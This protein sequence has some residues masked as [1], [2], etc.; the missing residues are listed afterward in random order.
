MD[1]AEGSQLPDD[2]AWM[3]DAAG[4]GDEEGLQLAQP[5]EPVAPEMA[6][7]DA[8]PATE[9]PEGA[10]VAKPEHAAQMRPHIEQL[11]G[12]LQGW[13]EFAKPY[14]GLEGVRQ[15]SPV[16][17][18]LYEADDSARVEK[19]LT[20]MQG[21]LPD[22]DMQGLRQRVVNDPTF[23]GTFA[24]QNEE[25]LL[26]YFIQAK[27]DTLR[28]KLGVAGAPT[29]LDGDDEFEDD[30]DEPL[31]QPGAVAPAANPE[32]EALRTQIAQLQEQLSGR[33]QQEAQSSAQQVASQIGEAVFGQTVNDS[34]EP[35]QM[36]GWDEQ[37][38]TRAYQIAQ[39]EFERDPQAVAAFKLANQFHGKPAFDGH[40]ARARDIFASKL[41]DAVKMVDAVRAQTRTEAA[42]KPLERQE[43]SSD[44]PSMDTADPN[45]K[46]F[47]DDPEAFS[48][49][50][51]RKM[52][53]QGRR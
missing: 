9:K 16:I 13:N 15:F 2:F 31:Q 52:Q 8:G 14:G 5:G 28:A 41:A 27:G 11:E 38:L 22:A 19:L 12:E 36:G 18:A 39:T 6:N 32:L 51:F 40:V 49:E 20:A 33:Q 3:R 30:D 53:A 17:E 10:D 47:F 46:G 43:L 35:L 25:A 24:D 42:A 1:N 37:H 45:A 26:D 48:K 34:F 29:P 50:V 44:K 4:N 7:P 21:I 23:L